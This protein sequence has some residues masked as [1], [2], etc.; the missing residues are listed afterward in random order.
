M[1]ELAQSS[2]TDRFLRHIAEY[3]DNEVLR[4]MAREV[5]QGNLKLADG[6]AFSTYADA[7][8]SKL[9]DFTR[10]YDGLTDDER[11]RE[12]A[13]ATAELEMLEA[14]LGSEHPGR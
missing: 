1:Y 7:L 12:A 8:A 11:A 13:G 2:V 3:G 9:T 6:I 5:R 10:W 14:R 4:E